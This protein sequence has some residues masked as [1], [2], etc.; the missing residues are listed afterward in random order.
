MKLTIA[1][2]LFAAAPA[3]IA[4]FH[5]W[6][7]PGPND[8]RAPC[9]MLNSL[10]NHGFLPH[11]GK[12]IS[13]N[14]TISALAAALNVNETLSE[15][16]HENAVTT[17]PVANATTFSLNDLSNH[18]ILEHDGSLSRADF[19]WG[20]DHTFNGT[21]FNETRSYWIDDTVTVQMAAN[22]RL[23]RVNTSNTTNPTFSMSNLGNAFSL[24]ESAA[25]IIALGD[26]YNG[27]VEKSRVE[28]LFENERLPLELGWSR[29][30]QN[31]DLGVL[32]DMLDRIINATGSD[33]EQAALLRRN[34]GFH[35]GL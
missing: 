12:D 15:F 34:G 1:L 9:P 26:R 31:I 33:A 30:E 23:A 8:V 2:T 10:A 24:G 32:Q 4:D 25:Y 6:A 17:N 22:A 35:A 5:S 29:P 20:D 21:V 18:N 28:Y 3:A 13:L 16:L 19:Y 14:I 7:P 11:D 27:T